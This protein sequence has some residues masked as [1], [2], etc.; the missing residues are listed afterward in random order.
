MRRIWAPWRMQYILNATKAEGCILCD[1]PAEKKDK[2]NYILFRGKLNF[3]M[4]NAF[5][6]TPGHVMV[7]PYRHIGNI[8]ELD[9][10]ESREH[11]QLVQLAVKLLTEETKPAGFNIG[12]N[13][14]KVAGA[15]LEG[16]IHTHVVPRWNGDHNF[17]TVVADIRVLGEGLNVTYDKLKSRL[18]LILK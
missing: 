4:L 3:I 12:M 15:G 17:M 1:K 8:M 9:D 16:H 13:L 2:A 7:A 5:P 18:S 6:Y 10:K 14:G 11:V